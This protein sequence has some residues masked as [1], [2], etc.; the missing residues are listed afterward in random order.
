MTRFIVIA[1]AKGG[2]GK[3]T[4]AINLAALLNDAGKNITL[5]DADL[6]A[7]NISSYLGFPETPVTLHHV[8]MGKNQTKEATYLH[9]SGFK[10]IPA[11]Y[12]FPPIENFPRKL[13]SVL[14]DLV[15]KTELA[16]IDSAATLGIETLQAL[17]PS[18]ETI[19]V[20][21]P[22]LPSVLDAKKTIKIAE[23][24]G[25]IVPGVVINRA[26]NDKH[27]LSAD[28]IKLIL[29]KPVIGIIPEDKNMRESLMIKQPLVYTHPYSPASRSFKQ[30]AEMLK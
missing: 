10:I 1:S 22:E 16:I 9:P 18:D 11:S 7:P 12:S 26:R 6:T 28:K 15:G 4:I 30:L 21:N 17:K 3:T 5:I 29:Q 2:T 24:Y 27:E 14:L 8:L 19:I 20:T 23:D 25:L 13:G